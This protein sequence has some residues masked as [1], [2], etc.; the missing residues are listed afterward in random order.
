M[1]ELSDEAVSIMRNTVKNGLGM[2]C[3]F[4]DD[5]MKLLVTL[6]Q[7]AVLAGLAEDADPK[8][9]VRMKKASEPWRSAHERILGLKL[10]PYPTPQAQE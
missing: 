1:S 4:V 7:R 5:D 9:L 10:C 8:S 3:T 6:A 2:N